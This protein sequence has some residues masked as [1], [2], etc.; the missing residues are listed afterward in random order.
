MG[1]VGGRY[2]DVLTGGQAEAL[3]NFP[4]IDIGFASGLGGVVQEEVLLQVLLIPVHL[5]TRTQ[6]PEPL[7]RVAWTYS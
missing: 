4:H 6:T 1:L 7:V 3:G 5:R 2:N